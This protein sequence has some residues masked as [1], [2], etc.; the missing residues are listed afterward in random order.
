[1]NIH[2]DCFK[3]ISKEF[4]ESFNGGFKRVSRKFQYSFKCVSW[5]FQGCFQRGCKVFQKNLVD[6]SRVFQRRFKEV[7]C[8]LALIAATQAEGGLV[9]I[10]QE[11]KKLEHFEVSFPPMQF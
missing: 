6:V 8:C 5:K 4:Q 2:Q 10:G 1:M 9:K 3:K 11:V 7:L